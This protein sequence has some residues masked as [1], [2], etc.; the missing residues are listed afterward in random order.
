MRA[1]DRLT[2]RIFG[3][4]GRL[5]LCGPG[6]QQH[7][8]LGVEREL[9]IGQGGDLAGAGSVLAVDRLAA[10]DQRIGGERERDR[11]R[12]PDGAEDDSLP[13]V[14]G[15]AARR[16]E[17]PLEVRGRLLVRLGVVEPSLLGLLELAAAQQRALVPVACNP[18]VGLDRQLV[19]LVAPPEI[20]V[21]R[22]DHLF[23]ARVDR[24]GLPELDPL[25]LRERVRHSL[26]RHVDA[27][28]RNQ[29]LAE[30]DRHAELAPAVLGLER[31]RADH[32][33]ER[34]RRPDAGVD[35][36]LPVGARLDVVEVE[37]DV[38]SPRL[39][40]RHQLAL[41]ELPGVAAR[42][43]DER[44]GPRGAGFGPR[45]GKPACAGTVGVASGASTH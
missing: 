15:P 31:L 37:P 41:D 26:V 35:A 20:G 1:Q 9:L 3:L 23:D 19:V 14:C 13:A 7:A 6:R 22:L 25:D 24:V 27:H 44:I 2:Q 17:V 11:E 28:D 5:R 32:E 18:V 12:E 29:R 42:V 33:D 40:C 30:L 43:R 21:D 16:D 8:Q 39:E 36:L 34:A 38:L 4:R 45:R 10:R